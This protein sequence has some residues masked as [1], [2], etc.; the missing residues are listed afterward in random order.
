MLCL[1]VARFPTGY[2]LRMDALFVI[3]F[4]TLL[5]TFAINIK[6]RGL[7][8]EGAK[9]AEVGNRK[10]KR[11]KKF[12]QIQSSLFLNPKFPNSAILSLRPLRTL[13]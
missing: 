2:V 1:L 3:R 4:L 7:N 6:I 5:I 10:I 13:R 9:Y 11:T 8:A 12:H